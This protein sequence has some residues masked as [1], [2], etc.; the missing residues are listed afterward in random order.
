[1]ISGLILAAAV[2]LAQERLETPDA[3]Q[4]EIDR[5][6]PATLA[7]REI[8]WLECPL[9][10]LARSRDEKKPIALWVFLGNPSDERC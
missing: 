5:I 4:A 2:A 7:W 10:A 1:M 6:R 3:V 9:E 8:P